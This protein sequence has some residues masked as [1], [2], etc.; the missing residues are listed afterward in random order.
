MTWAAC[1]QWRRSV[2]HKTWNRRETGPE[3]V[4]SERTGS[5]VMNVRVS[6]HWFLGYAGRCD[7]YRSRAPRWT[8]RAARRP[9]WWHS[10]S[11]E[12]TR[13]P[14]QPCR[15]CRMNDVHTDPAHI[16][17]TLVSAQDIGYT[18]SSFSHAN[19]HVLMLNAWI[20]ILSFPLCVW[21]LI[22]KYWFT[23]VSI[24][25]LRAINML[26]K[27]S[28]NSL[29]EPWGDRVCRRIDT[30]TSDSIDPRQRSRTQP[31]EV[32]RQVTW[33]NFSAV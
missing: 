19:A 29:T 2:P 9:R 12:S 32:P 5:D 16:T 33:S 18:P 14:R 1:P 21:G 27:R 11:L 22:N 20:S 4:L 13:C 24:R 6:M 26:H 3:D 7:Q 10:S 31:I 23:K 28:M 8:P 17:H 25:P 15:E 30:K